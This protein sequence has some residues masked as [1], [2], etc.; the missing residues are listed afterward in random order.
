MKVVHV[1]HLYHPSEG[2]VQFW[3][4]N[5]SERL[6]RDYGDDVTVVTTNSY[7]GP[8]RKI[9]KKVEPATEN[10]NG[11]K[12]IRF[13]YR[14]WH[15]KWA[16]FLFR[17]MRRLGLR[18]SDELRT[19]ATGPYSKEMKQYL[20]TVSA[21]AICASSS[22]YYYMQLPLWRMCN[23]FYFGSIH[24][25]EDESKPVLN[26]LQLQ[27]I[28]SSKIYLANTFYEKARLVKA[29]V[30]SNKIK[31]LGVGVDEKLF[32][33][34]LEEKTA[35]RN[36]LNIP[37]NGILIGYAGRIERTKSVLVLV[38]SFAELASLNPDLYLVIAGAGSNYVAE[39][40]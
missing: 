19:V 9:F 37:G 4:K 35:C 2:G 23:F 36:A 13:S 18:I 21:D 10:I 25:S 5:V 31:V 24:L 32:D 28:N 40:E 7:Y 15:L 12:V 3:F 39:L 26:E 16:S 17:I 27:C 22:N 8:E 11:V 20:M 14:R 38:K 29:G 34:S 1:C 6:V 30:D 33:I